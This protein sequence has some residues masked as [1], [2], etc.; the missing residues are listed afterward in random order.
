M[1][2]FYFNIRDGETL[3]ADLEGVEMPSAKDAL[4]EATQAARDLL[5]N[6]VRNGD[7]IDGQQF[8]VLDELHMPI[9]T[10]PFKDV[11]RHK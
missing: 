2:R 5:A 10:L 1:S 7:V 8:E 9:F 3:I 6:K 4:E 11:L